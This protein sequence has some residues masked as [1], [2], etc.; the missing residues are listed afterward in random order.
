MN[1]TEH[2]YKND[3]QQLKL[4]LKKGYHIPSRLHGL[5]TLSLRIAL[6]ARRENADAHYGVT[7]EPGRNCDRLLGKSG[8]ACGE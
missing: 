8:E 2:Q 4:M 6:E 3:E 1:R 5:A 7:S